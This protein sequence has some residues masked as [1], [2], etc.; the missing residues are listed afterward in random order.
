[1]PIFPTTSNEAVSLI[2]RK[3]LYLLTFD[4]TEICCIVHPTDSKN[5][6]VSIQ[7]IVTAIRK[8]ITVVTQHNCK[9]KDRISITLPPKRKSLLEEM[10]NSDECSVSALAG[11]FIREGM[12]ERLSRGA[13]EDD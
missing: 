6:D 11:R 5:I 8:E 13:G 10:A 3:T 4:N 9:R 12:D 1:M 2:A 7:D